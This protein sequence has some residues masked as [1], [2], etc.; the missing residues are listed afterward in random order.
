[1]AFCNSIQ[2]KIMK[3]DKIPLLKISAVFQDKI[4]FSNLVQLEIIKRNKIAFLQILTVFG[5]CVRTALTRWG[6]KINTSDKRPTTQ[7]MKFSI[8][9]SSINLTKDTKNVD[10]ITFTNKSL[11]ENFI[12]KWP[13]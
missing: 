7:K 5:T 8:R 9:I 2:L 3:Q 11:T 13:R 1:M 4:T 10:F 6:Y 12:L